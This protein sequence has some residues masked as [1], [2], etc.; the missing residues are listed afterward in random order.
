MPRTLYFPGLNGIRCLAAM[1]VIVAHLELFKRLSNIEH[2]PRL[3]HFGGPAVTLFFV[4]S[5]FLITYLLL[6]EISE[7]S[8]IDIKS[9]YIRRVLRIWPLYY[10]IV[11]LGFFILPQFL[12]FEPWQGRLESGF[13][14]HF[15]FY[16]LLTPNIAYSILGPIP[17]VS[18]L[19]SIGVE[20]QFYI[21]WPLLL[22]RFKK[23]PFLILVAIILVFLTLRTAFSF[24]TDFVWYYDVRGYYL[25]GFSILFHNLQFECMAIGG[26]A[27]LG[28]HRWKHHI[29]KALYRRD[30]QLLNIAAILSLILLK[31][32]L[33]M[34]EQS[35]FGA[36]FAILILNVASNPKSILKLNNRPLNF[37]GKISY[38]LYAYHSIAIIVILKILDA[39]T[40][41]PLAFNLIFYVTAISS[42]ILI[43]AIS[44]YAFEAR[45]LSL[46]KNYR[47]A[48]AERP[49]VVRPREAKEPQT[50]GS[51]R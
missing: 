50:D 2:L 51:D 13:S 35:V 22:R 28:L 37:L 29:L 16:M 47:P 23:K 39:K 20:E 44:Y 48:P 18:I 49:L 6:T 5:G 25:R 36:L 27:A 40:L 19:W 33:A 26:L 45:F 31:P 9:F 34:F 10:L 42:T 15:L 14:A 24:Y 41:S 32:K 17:F 4:L 30:I 38:G 7:R 3:I 8:T 11:L 43:S 21:L 1:A 46:K 12:A